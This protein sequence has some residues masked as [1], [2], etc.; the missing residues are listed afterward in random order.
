[1]KKITY[2]VFL[3]VCAIGF[4]QQPMVNTL[5]ENNPVR[6]DK[7]QR[8]AVHSNGILDNSPKSILLLGDNNPVTHQRSAIPFPVNQQDVQAEIAADLLYRSENPEVIS[9]VVRNANRPMDDI[10]PT[11][12]ATESFTPNV[13]DHFFDP[14][15][16]GGSNTDGD[17][18]NYPNCGCA[19]QTTLLGVTE[20]EFID[21]MVFATFDYL[22]IYDGTDATGTLLYDNGDGG[23][24]DN[25]QNL[26]DMI[27]SNGSATFT[28]TS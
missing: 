26:T 13:G 23:M 25:D 21:F 1:M 19:T 17:A 8:S 3:L 27:A 5:G 2:S 9:S 24:N 11:A 22:Q 6:Y 12:G 15:G 14:G 28:S 18:G 20:I 16:P 4:S 10:I 7:Q